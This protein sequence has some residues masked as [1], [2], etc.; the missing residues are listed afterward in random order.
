VI[1]AALLAA[2][3]LPALLGVLQAI[4]SL[5]PLAR[6]LVPLAAL[7]ALA[8][9]LFAPEGLIVPVPWF[10][11]GAILGLDERQR[12]FLLFTALLWTT[13]AFYARDYLQDD[14]Q[15]TRFF[16]FFLVTMTG[17]LGLVLSADL[18]A[19][20][21]FFALM[22]F[23]A[24]GLVVHEESA[25]ARRAGRIYILLVMLGEAFLL[26]SLWYVGANAPALDLA[27]AAATLTA[28]PER[29]LL[30]AGLL[31]GFG[32]KAGALPLHFWLPLAC[33]AG[34]ISC[35]WAWRRCRAGPGSFRPWASPPPSTASCSAS[36][37]TGRRPCSPIRA[38]ARW[39]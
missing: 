35:P 23:A 8:T 18:A 28:L 22:S 10:L 34:S 5:R 30:I 36:P 29:D 17:N 4:P 9:A 20:Y 26:P 27:T 24:Y 7:P 13:A 2:I 3:A 37:R 38:S 32:I 6:P 14:P 19:F 21:F 31:L 15:R 12:V 25:E 1:A 33:S 39:G 16:A 11:F